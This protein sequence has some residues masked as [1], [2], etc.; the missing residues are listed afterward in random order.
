MS[1]TPD[2]PG[3]YITE[4]PSGSRTLTGVAT[5]VTAFVGRA[6]RGPVDTAVPIGSF[7]DFVNAFGPLWRES[8][9][10]YAVR[11][12]YLNGGGPAWVVRVV[13]DAVTAE[14]AIGD[15]TLEGHGP[16]AWANA[17]TAV[18]SHPDCN[19]LFTLELRVGDEVE[20]FVDLTVTDGP[21]RIDTVLAG[22]RLARVKGAVP[23]ARPEA[24]T[25]GIPY[26]VTTEGS[27]GAAP[28]A[29]SYVPAGTTR[30]GLRALEAV[31]LINILV[32]PPVAPGGK[33]PDGVWAAAL[34][35]VQERR[36]FLIVDPPPDTSLDEVAGWVTTSAGL[37]GPDARNAAVYF[38]RIK[39]SDPLRDGAV[40]TFAASGAIAG[41]YART[42]ANRGVWKAPA[43]IETGIAG[44]L[45]PAQ[46][47][48]DAENSRL[49]A[50]GINA[51]RTFPGAGTV[52]WGARTLRGSDRLADEYKYVPVRRLALFL[53]ESLSR[54]T[55]WVVFEPNDE[56]LWAQI[57]QSVG[58]FLEDLFRKGAFQGVTPRDA[59]FVRCGRETTTQ[60][61]IDRGVVNI[62]V[63]FAPLKPAEFL[64]IRIQ[65]R[66]A[67]PPT[68]R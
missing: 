30:T 60:S 48:T 54:G 66:T 29:D 33:L 64:L 51:I 16:G 34:S 56:P 20:T 57:R 24:S 28:D 17:L 10:G 36:A 4:V 25:A 5:S 26:T 21:R 65:Q 61:D 27:D 35:V 9:L 49:T 2:H 47:L 43:G 14:I 39:A 37:V 22:S 18:V 23:A 12:F 3:V 40:G 55:Q 11:D 53:E 19:G 50:E 13:K 31:D 42:D 32:L 68:E 52:A 15:L 59:Y 7:A 58:A 6:L 8:G 63:G 46:V 38:P 44:A 62:E 67:L 41:A 45:G 1:I